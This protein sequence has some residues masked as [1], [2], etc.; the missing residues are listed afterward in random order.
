MISVVKR[1]GTKEE[2]IPEKIVA[3]IS[4]VGASSKIARNIAKTVEGKAYDG[5]TTSKIREIVLSALSEQNSELA[6][7]WVLYERAIKK[8]RE[9][10]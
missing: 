1:Y 2:F 6:T 4:K 10:E 8:R 5:I 3:S 7:N 9:Q